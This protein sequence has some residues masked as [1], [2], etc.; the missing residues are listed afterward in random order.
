MCTNCFLDSVEFSRPGYRF[1]KFKFILQ[2][3][4][5]TSHFQLCFQL[6]GLLGFESFDLIAEILANRR[7]IREPSGFDLLE[8][9][10]NFDIYSGVAE[11]IPKIPHFKQERGPAI[12]TQVCGQ[13]GMWGS[14]YV[15]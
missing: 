9:E 3:I 15:V 5:P 14:G 10:S 6:F 8:E 4:G 13:V 11:N 7:V 12:S 1:Y 2:V